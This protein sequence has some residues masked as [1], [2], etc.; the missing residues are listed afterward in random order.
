[1]LLKSKSQSNVYLAKL[2]IDRG[3]ETSSGETIF[4]SQFE[5]LVTCGYPLAS[6]FPLPS[7]IESAVE[8]PRI[9]SVAD[10]E[11]AAPAAAAAA[12]EDAAAAAAV[13]DAAA[14]AKSECESPM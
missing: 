2:V 1:M 6:E 11:E 14:A 8:I 9:D 10:E 3:T 12:V 5:D 4:D 13:E 7:Q